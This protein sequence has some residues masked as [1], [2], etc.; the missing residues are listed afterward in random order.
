[1]YI[2][3]AKILEWFFLLNTFMDIYNILKV[4]I[5][6]KSFSRHE[7]LSKAMDASLK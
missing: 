4:I 5:K 6:D 3:V 1:M 2:L 7:V